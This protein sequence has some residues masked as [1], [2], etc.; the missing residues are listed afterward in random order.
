MSSMKVVATSLLM[1]I[2]M[3]LI[4]GLTNLTVDLEQTKPGLLLQTVIAMAV[5]GVVYL[6]ASSLLRVSEL[7]EITAVVRARI[8]RERGSP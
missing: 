6:A 8:G 3:F 4:I 2:A 7:A 5:G 1:G